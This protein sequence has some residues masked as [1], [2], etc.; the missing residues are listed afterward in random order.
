VDLWNVPIVKIKYQA[1]SARVAARKSLWT[2]GTACIAALNW[3]G[4]NLL[5]ETKRSLILR[6]GSF[7]PMDPAQGL[8]LTA[9][10]WNAADQGKELKIV[11]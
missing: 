7:V 11:D 9:N 4:R 10:A 2:A 5:S 6:T 3:K 8:S 1:R